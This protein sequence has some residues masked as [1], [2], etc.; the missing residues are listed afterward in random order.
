MRWL[1]ALRGPVDD[2]V[3]GGLKDPIAP[4]RWGQTSGGA[5][6]DMQYIAHPKYVLVK[7]STVHQYVTDVT[8]IVVGSGGRR[9]MSASPH[10]AEGGHCDD[11]KEASSPQ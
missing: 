4:W 11:E 5:S 1:G 2:R 8:W 7:S 3:R 6:I 10:R 9:V